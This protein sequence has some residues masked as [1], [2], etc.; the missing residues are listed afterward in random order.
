MNQKNN[1]EAE[2]TFDDDEVISKTA[3][4]KA[5]QELQLM[6]EQLV[7]L[8]NKKLTLLPI[9]DTILDEIDLTKKIKHGN[10]RRR[11]LQRIA[12]LLRAENHEEIKEGLESFTLK[13]RR[14]QV[15]TSLSDNWCN[16]LISEDDAATCF[17]K[18]YP[19]C[20]RQHLLQLVRHAKK[21]SKQEGNSGKY[22]QRLFKTIG[23][24]SSASDH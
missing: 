3:I 6:G 9:S 12:K 22:K 15:D 23:A 4:K 1:K 19:E 7:E 17:L 18:E 21:E 13:D 24:I 20:D 16:R 10:A 14:H 11:Q 5:M 8:S 2:N